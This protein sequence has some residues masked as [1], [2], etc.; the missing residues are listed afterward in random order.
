MEMNY[1]KKSKKRIS[2]HTLAATNAFAKSIA[3]TTE[4]GTIFAL[5]GE[6]G[7]GKTTFVQSLGRALGVR[8]RIQSPTFGLLSIY[9]TRNGTLI[10]VDCYRLKS[11]KEFSTIGFEELMEQPNTIA[12]IEWANKIKSRLSGRPVIWLNFGFMPS[13][14]RVCDLWT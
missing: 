9:K 8:R 6:L 13:G 5:T 11:L 7:A 12:A 2:L 14:E 1:P 3:K 4:P 10:H